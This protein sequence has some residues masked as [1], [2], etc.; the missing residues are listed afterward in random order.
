MT[1]DDVFCSPTIVVD[2][3]YKL[4]FTTKHQEKQ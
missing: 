1:T 4:Q 3:F 2:Y